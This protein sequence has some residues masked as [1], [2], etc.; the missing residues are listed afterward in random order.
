M[1][2][3][4]ITSSLGLRSRGK[5]FNFLIYFFNFFNLLCVFYHHILRSLRFSTFV[6]A[7]A[8]PDVGMQNHSSDGLI[9]QEREGCIPVVK[10]SFFHTLVMLKVPL[11]LKMI[12][13]SRKIMEHFSSQVTE[14]KER[15][16]YAVI[17]S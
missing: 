8:N 16:I 10:V 7:R 3:K 6:E 1:M 17:F 13:F 11:L 9:P 4:S 14:V 2:V 12:S 15:V 5:F